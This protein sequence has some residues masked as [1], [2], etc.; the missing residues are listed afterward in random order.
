LEANLLDSWLEIAKLAQQLKLTELRL[1][2]NNLDPRTLI[3]AAAADSSAE[4]KGDAK[5]G[6]AEAGSLPKQFQSCFAQLKVLVLNA[7]PNAW[8]CVRF[9]TSWCAS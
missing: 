6:G 8:N 2:R 4:S 7:V 9:V 3:S 1:S 5:A